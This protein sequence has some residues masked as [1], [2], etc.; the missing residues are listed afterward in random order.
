MQDTDMSLAASSM[1]PKYTLCHLP[2][3]SLTHISQDSLIGQGYVCF[4]YEKNLSSC[5]MRSTKTVCKFLLP[6]SPGSNRS[7]RVF[8]TDYRQQMV[9][10][11]LKKTCLFIHI[12]W[13]RVGGS[14]NADKRK[15]RRCGSFFFIILL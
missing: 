7:D 14:A 1:I 15:V 6:S 9:R 11:G 3:F 8:Y 5:H 13:I 4:Y 10:E 2:S 12:L